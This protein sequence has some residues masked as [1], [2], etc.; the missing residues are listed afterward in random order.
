MH[1]AA[2]NIRT[3]KP[4]ELAIAID[5]AEKRGWGPGLHDAALFI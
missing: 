4:S 2:L 3:M 5:W 1:S